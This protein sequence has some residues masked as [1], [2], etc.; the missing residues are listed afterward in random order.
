MLRCKFCNNDKDIKY[1]RSE[2]GIMNTTISIYYC[3][4]CKKIFKIV[5]EN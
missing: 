4:K 2:R 1:V 3:T 5:T